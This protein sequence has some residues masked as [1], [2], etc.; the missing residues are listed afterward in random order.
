MKGCQTIASPNYQSRYETLKSRTSFILLQIFS[1]SVK[2]HVA[3]L[4]RG[5]LWV[6]CHSS[7]GQPIEFFLYLSSLQYSGNVHHDSYFHHES[8]VD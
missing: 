2:V 1:I 6:S 3:V 5:V 4:Q 7:C 8:R